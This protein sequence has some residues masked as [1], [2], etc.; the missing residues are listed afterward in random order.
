VTGA[1]T[2]YVTSYARLATTRQAV[3]PADLLGRLD[4]L[5]VVCWRAANGM[6]CE[7]TN[8]RDGI[9]YISL[10]ESRRSSVLP[11]RP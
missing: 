4:M 1:L 6:Y 10:T 7:G 9:I 2:A 3:T 8:A 11:A 5:N